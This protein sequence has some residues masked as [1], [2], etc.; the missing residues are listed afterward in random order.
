[1]ATPDIDL[2]ILDF[3]GVLTDNRVYLL[4]DGRETVACHRGDG[5]GIKLIQQAGIEVLILS[6]EQN[7]VVSA[8]A[9]K[10]DINCIQGC[11]DKGEA[12]RE[13]INSRG[14]TPSRVMYVGNDTN[15]IEAMCYVGHPVAPSDAHP[16][17]REIATNVTQAAGGYGVV[18]EIADWI[19][20]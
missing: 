18:R 4:E 6:T 13:I 5:W 20:G 8:R 3:D 19:V 9:K 14:L 16:E 11:Q 10:L 12:T 2:I 1:M 17:I 7:P 15:D